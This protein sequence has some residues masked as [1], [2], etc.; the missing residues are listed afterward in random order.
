MSPQLFC[1][2]CAAAIVNEATQRYFDN[3]WE[4]RQ[5]MCI[6]MLRLFGGLS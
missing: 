5:R 4:E 3:A 1:A 6:G 2:K